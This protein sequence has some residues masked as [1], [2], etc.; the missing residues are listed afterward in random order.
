MEH[1]NADPGSAGEGLNKPRGIGSDGMTLKE[2][3]AQGRLVYETTGCYRGI[4]DPHV[5]QRDP[6]KA[7]LLHTR[8]LSGLIAGR[9]KTRMISASPYVREVSELAIGIYT[10]EGDNIAQ[11]TGIQ[12]HSRSMGEALQWMIEQDWEGRVGIEPGDL[13]WFNECSIA[14]MHPADVYDILPIFWHGELVAWVVTVIME[15]DIGAISPGCMPVPN[16]ERA[17]DGI[18]FAGEKVGTRDQLRHDI[19]LKCELSFDMSNVFLLDRKGA[20]AANIH[21]RGEVEKMVEEF[22]LDYF[23]SAC[24][25]LI[26]MERRNQLLRLR[27]MTVPG[28]YRNV[29]VFEYFMKDQPLTWLAARKDVIRIAPFETR[30]ETSGRVTI[31]LEGAGHWGWHSFNATPSGM[32]GCLAISLVQTLS[33]DGRANLGSLLPF[34]LKLPKNSIF[35]PQDT[36]PLAQAN[37]WAT[38]I[39]SFGIWLTSLSQSYYMRGFRE[40]MLGFRSAF[41]IAMAGYDQYGVR[42]PMVSGTVGTIGAAASAVRDG[43]SPGGAV[44]VPHVD[45]GN[46]EIW[47]QFLPYLDLSRRLNPYSVGPGKYRSGLSMPTM[48]LIFGGRDITGGALLAGGTYNILPNL[49]LGGGYPGAKL[50]RAIIRNTNAMELIAEGKPL[51]AQLGHPANPDFAQMLEGDIWLPHHVPEPFELKTGDVLVDANGAAGGYGDPLEREPDRI[52]QDLEDGLSTADIAARIH[53]VVCSCGVEDGHWTIDPAAT[54]A[55]RQQHRQ[56]RRARAIPVQTWWQRSRQSLAQRQ[57]HPLIGEMYAS[58]MAMSQ[59]FADEF[60]AFWALPET[61][62]PEVE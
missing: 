47:E 8:M 15:M 58:S 30:I 31:D 45:V 40:E 4:T 46:V 16:I 20:I 52:R 17:T 54:S 42:R 26:E 10:P 22:G 35:N 41:A 6:V 49:G 33:C 13:F 51:P 55:L 9:E 44:P 27:R 1:L 2:M 39:E 29:G 57:F 5:L 7:E 12:A 23:K 62:T 19:H 53:G 3:L 48:S 37:I 34:D 56:E 38:T 28:R 32:W 24:G 61:W 36:R 18:R 14:G 25:E 50:V 43:L 21:I 11:S 60:R 59:S